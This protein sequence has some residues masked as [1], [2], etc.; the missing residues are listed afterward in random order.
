[1]ENWN[2]ERVLCYL[3]TIIPEPSSDEYIL[4]T[5]YSFLCDSLQFPLGKEEN[6]PVA[7]DNI[8]YIL[9]L[10]IIHF[11]FLCIVCKISI[12]NITL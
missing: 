10:I 1:M 4:Q 2:A 7:T 8:V 12:G 11:M 3:V 5:F 6:M 9:F